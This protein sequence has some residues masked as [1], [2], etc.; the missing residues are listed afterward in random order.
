M[1]YASGQLMAEGI[2]K[3]L[4]NMLNYAANE[5]IDELDSFKLPA[6]LKKLLTT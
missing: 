5:L 2:E 3:N 4:E 1:G 6:F